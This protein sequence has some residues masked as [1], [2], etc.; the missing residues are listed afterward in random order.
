MAIIH[1][2]NKRNRKNSLERYTRALTDTFSLFHCY[3]CVCCSYEKRAPHT[4]SDSLIWRPV[5]GTGAHRF[6]DPFIGIWPSIDR[7]VWSLIN[8]DCRW[9]FIIYGYGEK[10]DVSGANVQMRA[11]I[12]SVRRGCWNGVDIRCFVIVNYVF[13]SIIRL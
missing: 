7:F 8:Y 3:V 11:R 12:D 2:A 9:M 5:C 6:H 10:V 4:G 13:F 1:F